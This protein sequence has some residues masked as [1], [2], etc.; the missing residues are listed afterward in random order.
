M[1]ASNSH[2]KIIL[3]FF[4]LFN[5]SIPPIIAANDSTNIFQQAKRYADSVINTG[6]AKLDGIEASA[7]ETIQ[8][9]KATDLVTNANNAINQANLTHI[10]KEHSIINSELPVEELKH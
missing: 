9:I 3:T 5:L 2:K 6:N 4:I 8:Q 7:S 10:E 1:T